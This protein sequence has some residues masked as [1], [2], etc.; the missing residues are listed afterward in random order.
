MVCFPSN[1]EV[2]SNGLS[3]T[4]IRM[5]TEPVPD[6]NLLGI[7]SIVF[8]DCFIVHGVRLNRT[9]DGSLEAW[10]PHRQDPNRPGYRIDSAH[11]LNAGLNQ[12]IV[13]LLV[14]CYKSYE[15]TGQKIVHKEESHVS[16]VR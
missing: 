1:L 5:I 6:K 9:K 15:E 13:N 3:I 12:D 14:F 2:N 11:P 7:Y 10:M 8:N 4:T 16:G